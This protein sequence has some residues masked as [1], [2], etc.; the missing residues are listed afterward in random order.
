LAPIGA[1]NFLVKVAPKEAAGTS[2]EYEST[3]LAEMF[4]EI[5]VGDAEAGSESEESKA[6]ESERDTPHA[7]QFRIP[8]RT[9][10]VC[11]CV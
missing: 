7:P 9:V 3:Q 1:D 11:G 10:C 8:K 5:E 2:D 6:E 4:L